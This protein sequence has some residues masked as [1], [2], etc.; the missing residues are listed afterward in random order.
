[1]AFKFVFVSALAMLLT[2]SPCA[3]DSK[4]TLGVSAPLTGPAAAWG[5]D[6]KNVI[7]FA[8]E[9]LADGKYTLRFE[10]DKCTPKEAVTVAHKLIQ[11]DKVSGVFLVCGGTVLGSAPIYD[12]ANVILMAPLATP[13]A[14]SK[15]GEYVFRAGISDSHSARLL[16]E[17]ISRRFKSAGVFTELDEYS[18]AFLNELTINTD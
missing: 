4:V 2:G 9:K 8:N 1:M 3:A 6:L 16:A 10:D 17:T 13:P 11:T 14:I 5:A 7:T 18:V 12:R 15:A